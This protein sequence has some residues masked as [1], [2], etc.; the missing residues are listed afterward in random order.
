MKVLVEVNDNKVY[1]LL[2]ILND[3]PFVKTT[4]ISSSKNL[5]VK[6]IQEAAAEMKL[7]KSGKKKARNAEAFLNEL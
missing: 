3:L 7:I 4:E 6:Q 2:E 5:L 1:E